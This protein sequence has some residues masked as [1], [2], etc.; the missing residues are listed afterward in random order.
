[1]IVASVGGGRERLLLVAPET[2]WQ[3]IWKVKLTWGLLSQRWCQKVLFSRQ[4]GICSVF[5]WLSLVVVFQSHG[6]T[7]FGSLAALTL[8]TVHGWGRKRTPVYDA[9]ESVSCRVLA[10]NLE[11][12]RQNW[13]R[14]R[15]V[16]RICLIVILASRL[17]TTTVFLSYD[18][19]LCELTLCLWLDLLARE[20][21][22]VKFLCCRHFY[23]SVRLLLLDKTLARWSSDHMFGNSL[24][25]LLLLRSFSFLVLLLIGLINCLI[26][27]RSRLC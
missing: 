14:T 5:C 3:S 22:L 6:L 20:V 2:L 8:C 4:T 1:M 18:L 11:L 24:N 23:Q 27:A 21:S 16:G 26:I 13:R 17:W 15:L 7:S 25:L 12:C 9:L 10:L 19:E